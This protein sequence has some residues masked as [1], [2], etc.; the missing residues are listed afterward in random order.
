MYIG[1]DHF[2]KPGDELAVA[3]RKGQ[4]QR[5]FQG[6]ATHGNCDLLA[7]GV[8]SISSIDN[9]F[10]QNVKDIPSYTKALDIGHAP[11]FK[12]LTL[13]DDDLLRR[14]VINQLICHSE[15]DFNTIERQHNIVFTRYFD[16]ALTELQPMMND[17]LVIRTQAGLQVS[18]DGRLL[19]RRICMAFDAYLEAQPIR[20][21]KII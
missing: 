15:L 1:M 11:I 8:S 3:Q 2:A 20:Y 16:K 18:D 19:I 17:Q 10:M 14:D 13:T 5:N 12:G 7:F 21:S 4:L 6:Y 9:T